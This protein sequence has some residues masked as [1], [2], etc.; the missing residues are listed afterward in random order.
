V[1]ARRVPTS[2]A[3]RARCQRGPVV[4]G[5]GRHVGRAPHTCPVNRARD[6]PHLIPFHRCG[7]ICMHAQPTPYPRCFVP[8]P[9]ALI[10]LS[11]PIAMDPHRGGYKN[12]ARSL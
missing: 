11:M 7:C 6:S 3:R 12:T 8:M 2:D 1:A 9:P 5:R 4:P 10:N